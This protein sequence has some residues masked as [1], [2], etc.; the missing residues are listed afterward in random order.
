MNH[1]ANNN[2]M[3]KFLEK[4]HVSIKELEMNFQDQVAKARTGGRGRH[5]GACLLRS[6]HF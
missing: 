6:R 5:N 4:K 2:P 3:G 1:E